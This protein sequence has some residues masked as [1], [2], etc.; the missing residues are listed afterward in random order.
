[1][2]GVLAASLRRVMEWLGQ[3]RLTLSTPPCI[4]TRTGAQGKMEAL[5]DEKKMV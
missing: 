2:A 4:L 1:M 5:H 3:D